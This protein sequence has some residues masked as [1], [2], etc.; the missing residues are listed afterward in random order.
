MMVQETMPVLFECING[1]MFRD[2][3][4][5]DSTFTGSM[6]NVVSTNMTIRS[7]SAD[8]MAANDHRS[9]MVQ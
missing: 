6:D 9:I 2:S 1:M 3:I 4:I 5:I 7:S 8:G